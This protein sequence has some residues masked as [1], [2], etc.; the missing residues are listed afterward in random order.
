MK[1]DSRGSLAYW[2]EWVEFSEERIDKVEKILQQPAVNAS[3]EPQYVRD[4]AW[5][6]L[7]LMLQYYSAGAPTKPLRRYFP[8][9]LD[10]WEEA[11]ALGK[12]VWS[13]HEQRLRHDWSLNLHHYMDCFWL[14]GLALALEVPDDQ[15]N[16]LV[17]L[18]GNEG[19]DALL[20]R[21]IGSRQAGRRVGPDL[22]FPKAYAGLLDVVNANAQDA[23][24]LLRRYV[25][26]WFKSLRNSGNKK[27]ER[28]LRTPYW[29]EYGDQNFEG[30]AYFG[31]WCIEAVAVVKAFNIDDTLCLDHPNYPGDLIQDGRS[32]RYPD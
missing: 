21:V 31:R 22:C 7:L 30:G 6:R 5:K 11:E 19:K 1:R 16:R 25:D 24:L 3:Y 4:Y 18:M 26:G 20:D 14:T 13:E 27:V 2:N 9:L 29:Y 12:D 28:Y 10:N 8:G 23:P 32:P 17:A 15:W